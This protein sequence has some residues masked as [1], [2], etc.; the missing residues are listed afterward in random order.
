[1]K[2][3]THKLFVV[4]KYIKAVSALDAIK[5]DKSTPVHECW[6][7]EKWSEEELPSAIGFDNGVNNEED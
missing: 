5:K 6:L 1:M 3:D 7:E 2:R 4:R